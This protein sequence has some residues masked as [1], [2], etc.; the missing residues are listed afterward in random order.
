MS[1]CFTSHQHA[2]SYGDEAMAYTGRIIRKTEDDWGLVEKSSCLSTSVQQAQNLETTSYETSCDVVLTSR[3]CL[4]G[5]EE[6]AGSYT[7]QGWTQRG[8]LRGGGGGGHFKSK[9]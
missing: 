9:A 2:R 1:T 3:A 4:L 6:T 5:D 7:C 8:C